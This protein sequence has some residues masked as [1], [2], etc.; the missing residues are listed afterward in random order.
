M[1]NLSLL[2]AVLALLLV[3]CAIIAFE[4]RLT[5]IRMRN[6]HP[7]LLM[8]DRANRRFNKRLATIQR[9]WKGQEHE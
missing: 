4:V 2:G 5:R 8:A 9:S 6:I 7:D 1:T 3:G